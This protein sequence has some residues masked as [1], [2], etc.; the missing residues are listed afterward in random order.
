MNFV[1][2]PIYR[3]DRNIF[4]TVCN[5]LGL[6]FLL[7]YKFLLYLFISFLYFLV[8]RVARCE[9]FADRCLYSQFGQ[10]ER[11]V[12]MCLQLDVTW[13]QVIRKKSRRLNGRSKE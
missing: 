13:L 10:R 4:C 12:R 2:I 8:E 5:R 3:I 1:Q 11:P 7:F 9:S 6:N